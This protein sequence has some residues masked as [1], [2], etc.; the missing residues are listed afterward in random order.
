MTETVEEFLARGGQIK[1][2]PAGTGTQYPIKGKHGDV[3]RKKLSTEAGNAL[4]ARGK[5]A[6][7]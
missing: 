2:V 7:K 3:L 6:G 5:G 4:V 1:K